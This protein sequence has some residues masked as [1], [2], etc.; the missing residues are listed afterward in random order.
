MTTPLALGSLLA[1][2]VPQS[3]AGRALRAA[4]DELAEVRHL[5]NGGMDPLSGDVRRAQKEFVKQ[6]TASWPAHFRPDDP[7]VE[8]LRLRADAADQADLESV[9]SLAMRAEPVGVVGQVTVRFD[10]E[11]GHEPASLDEPS[12]YYYLALRR[13]QVIHHD[14]VRHADWLA[15]EVTDGD[16]DPDGTLFEA[17]RR[18]REVPPTAPVTP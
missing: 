7:T 10:V 11:K 1:Q 17:I 16:I 13:G 8:W 18:I 5:I 12:G 15:E 4:A 14:L 3:P 2:P 6:V 9:N